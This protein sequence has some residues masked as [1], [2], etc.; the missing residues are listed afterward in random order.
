LSSQT[1]CKVYVISNYSPFIYMTLHYTRVFIRYSTT[2]RKVSGSMEMLG[3]AWNNEGSLETICF[4]AC[5]YC[6]I[7]IFKTIKYSLKFYKLHYFQEAL[8]AIKSYS[9]GKRQER[10]SASNTEEY[11]LVL[12][13]LKVLIYK[14]KQKRMW[15]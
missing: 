5:I 4:Y 6:C 7:I 2:I 1:S 11:I 3:C 13:M 10:C 14:I 12:E 15:Y 8:K 9:H